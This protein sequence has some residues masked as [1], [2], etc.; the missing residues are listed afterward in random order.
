MKKIDAV[1][2]YSYLRIENHRI[3]NTVFLTPNMTLAGVLLSGA[4]ETYAE[5]DIRRHDMITKYGF[6]YYRG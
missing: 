6:M 2:R 4:R 5:M 3:F 1:W